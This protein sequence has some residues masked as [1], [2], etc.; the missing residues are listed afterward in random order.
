MAQEKHKKEHV[1]EVISRS[2]DLFVLL[3]VSVLI[4]ALFA[5]QLSAFANN[6]EKISGNW[7]TWVSVAVAV[8]LTA[9]S[10][11]I[12]GRLGGACFSG[13]FTKKTIYNPPVW[14]F[15]VIS[16][17]FYFFLK[18][19]LF[20]GGEYYRTDVIVKAICI[21]LGVF[22]LGGV[23]S[24]IINFIV[25]G[26]IDGNRRRK[27]ETDL[28]IKAPDFDEVTKDPVM[29]IEWIQKEEP[30]AKPSQDY[31]DFAVFAQ[32]IADILKRTPIKTI[33]LVGRYGSG[34]SSI[35]NMVKSYIESSNKLKGDIQ[36]PDSLDLYPSRD[37]IICQVSGWGFQEGTAAQHVLQK[38]IKQLE[39]HTDCLSITT[40]PA[41]YGKAIGDSGNV[42]ARII[43]AILCGWQS[44][45][46]ILKKLDVLLSRIEKRMVIFLEDIDRNTRTEV[47]FNEI[48]AL[49]EGLKGL[50][51]VTFVLAIGEE[52]RGKEV[53]IKISEHIETIPSMPQRQVIEICKTFR[54][55]CLGMLNTNVRGILYGDKEDQIGWDRSYIAEYIA[56]YED[57]LKKPIDYLLKILINPRV[58]KA[59][60][61]R[62]LQTW[63]NLYGEI[64][65][66]DLLMTNI[67]RSGATEAF[68]FVNENINMIRSLSSNVSGS[69]E[70]KKRCDKNRAGLQEELK[71]ATENV[72]WDFESTNELIN[73]LF[74]GWDDSMSNRNI[75]SIE[76][77]KNP[78]KVYNS[79]PTDY[80]G[81]LCREQV[82]IDEI[83]DQEV[84][85][86]L[87]M[88]KVGKE[89]KIFRG[90]KPL[91]AI[92]NNKDFF[93]KAMQFKMLLDG[94][95]VRCLSEKQFE[96]TLQEYGNKTNQENCTGF[97]ELWQLE[98]ASP[99]V[100]HGTWIQYEICK[101]LKTSL[102]FAMD[103]YHYYWKQTPF[104]NMSKLTPVQLID[105]V[106]AEAKKT[107]ENKPEV[108]IKVL[109]SKDMWNIRNF[110][111]TF[112][113]ER[114]GEEDHRKRQWSWLSNVILKAAEM[115]P[116]KIVPQIVPLVVQCDQKPTRNGWEYNCVFLKGQADIL[117]KETM[118]ELM[119]LLNK[120]IKTSDF[121][122][123]RQAVI[124]CARE[125]ANEWLSK[126]KD[127][128]KG[129]LP[130]K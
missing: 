101:A 110:A 22:G 37:I 96:L 116:Q 9:I 76:S 64:D 118:S 65:F 38:A 3:V 21:T 115:N 83:R 53:L 27:A 122:E 61:R 25:G 105:S 46:D 71:K 84:I 6:L 15:G 104:W 103:L 70:A 123:I 32:R 90:L 54:D 81:R 39:K 18:L 112:I 67:L 73:Y 89:E 72:K 109:N 28:D 128:S 68:I 124:N 94:N 49:L 129:E 14:F 55:Y 50:Q 79:E 12:L 42:L 41:R 52:H 63:Q 113:F 10:W 92:L 45:F 35:L 24:Y 80:W 88:W 56:Q 99:V 86:S 51:N 69:S 75:T 30:I 19:Y 57:Y 125:A 44:P 26:Y 5:R 93:N 20:R 43:G 33:G 8:M 95:K 120:P 111:Q 82:A 60:L 34:K 47:F 17:I 13:F 1:R 7:N 97:D 98:L 117:F 66:D 85:N 31:F 36:E 62:T 4:C 107:Y 108:L 102:L 87:T 16:F 58:T 2:I 121:D 59:A 23:I 29:L 74:P 100:H 106:V 119:S 40:L 127:N 77:L 48:S 11:Y 114:E 126:N 91:D 130:D 78:Q